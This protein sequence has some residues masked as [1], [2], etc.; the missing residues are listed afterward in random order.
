MMKVFIKIFTIYIFVLLLS[1]CGDGGGGIVAVVN[2]LLGLEIH[3]NLEIEQNSDPCEDSPCSPF[4]ICSSCFTPLETS[5][6]IPLIEKALTLFPKTISSF[7]SHFY[8]SSFC[9]SIWQPPKLV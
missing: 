7:T 2:Q 1:P 8:S 6:E 5:K 3:N 9:K 4:C